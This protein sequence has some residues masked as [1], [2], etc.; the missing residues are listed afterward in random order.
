MKT[1][2]YQKV[3]DKIVADL[4]QGERGKLQLVSVYRSIWELVCNFI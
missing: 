1:D 2:V 3:T 4:D